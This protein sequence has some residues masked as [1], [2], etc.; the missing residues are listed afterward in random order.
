MWALVHLINNLEFSVQAIQV[1]ATRVLS[2]LLTISEYSQPYL[3][4]NACFGL[5]DEQVCHLCLFLS[6][7]LFSFYSSEHWLFLYFL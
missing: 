5:D 7:N 1:G 6:F 2:M 3:S 4:G